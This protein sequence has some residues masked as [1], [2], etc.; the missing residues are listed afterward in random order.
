MKKLCI[1]L[2]L[3]GT[4][5]A[6]TT[7]T[8]NRGEIEKLQDVRAVTYAPAPFVLASAGKAA[9]GGLFGMIGGAVAASSMQRAGEE[10]IATYDVPDPAVTVR[11]RLA[12]ALTQQFGPGATADTAPTGDSLA[13]L[14]GKFGREAAVLDTNTANWQ[15]LY[16]PSDWSH[17]YLYY[18]ARARLVRLSDGKVLWQNYCVRQLRDPKESRRQVDD[19]RA[20]N[21]ALLKQ[22]AQEAADGCAEELIAHLQGRA[23]A[24]R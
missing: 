18:A 9:A 22:K 21:G 4:A 19:Y 14:R 16:Y 24:A 3:F 11:E 2:L 15:L 5:C 13:E 6:T 12:A 20:D 23:V 10:L 1:A 17:H 8:P 7:V